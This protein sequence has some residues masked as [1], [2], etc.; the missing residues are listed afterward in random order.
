MPA[1][2]AALL[3]DLDAETAAL[4][5]ILDLLSDSDWQLATPAP[6]WT[7]ADQVAHLAYFDDAAITAATRPEELRGHPDTPDR[8]RRERRHDRCPVPPPDPGRAS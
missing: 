7:V 4:L 6:G 8:R 5:A 2:L 3:A 1:D